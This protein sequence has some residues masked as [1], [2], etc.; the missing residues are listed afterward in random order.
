MHLLG[1]KICVVVLLALLSS[2]ATTRYGDGTDY[3]DDLRKLEQQLL[4]RP[5]DPAALRDI[6]VI[7]FQTKQYE[8]AKD[9]L[10]RSFAQVGDDSRTIFYYGMTHEFL[11]D[12]N[13]A[14]AV[15]IHY[16]SLSPLS[17]F[18]KLIEAR[19]RTLTQ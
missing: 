11:N 8:L 18:K 16:T 17:Q 15:Y 6:G 2:C 5:D 9:R 1:K 13:A 12:I 4:F 10:A 19:F 7:Y 3:S 14:L